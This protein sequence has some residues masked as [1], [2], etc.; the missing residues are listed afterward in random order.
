MYFQ[1]IQVKT[2]GTDMNITIANKFLL[3][4][5]CQVKKANIQL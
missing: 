3:I 2:S 4:D 1:T 5:S